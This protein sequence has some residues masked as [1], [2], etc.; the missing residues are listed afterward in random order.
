MVK[1]SCKYL[2]PLLAAL[3]FW[4]PGI[5]AQTPSLNGSLSNG[6]T[7]ELTSQLQPLVINR[8]HSW[9][10][11]LR[12]SQGQLLGGASIEV[13]GGM[14]EHDHGLPT[15]PVV[16]PQAE[17]G[18]YLLQGVRFHMPGYW[19]LAVRVSKSG[20]NEELLLDLQL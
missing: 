11:E 7:I 2:I 17:A 15:M 5:Q 6:W 12:D 1:L 14:P 20:F 13:S 9:H 18:M 8:L 4:A 16:S 19:Q 3:L 10:I